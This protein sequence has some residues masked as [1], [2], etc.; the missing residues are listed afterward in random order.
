M[1]KL[2]RLIGVLWIA[3]AFWIRL[4]SSWEKGFESRNRGF[5]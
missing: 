5:I 1:K 4:V 3:T 2:I